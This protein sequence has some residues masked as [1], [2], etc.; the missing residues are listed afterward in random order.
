[1]IVNYWP[2]WFRGL[3][4]GEWPRSY[5][6]VDIESSGY[7][8]AEDVVTEWGHCLVE[9]GKVV[10][11]LSLVIDWTG[12][13]NPPDH[14]LRRKLLQLDQGMRF[15]G[16]TCHMSHDLM[17][18][19]GMKPEKAFNFI[20]KFTDTIKEKRIPFVFHN[21]SFDEKMLAGNYLQFKFGKGFSFG[22]V[23]IDTEGVEK[24]SQAPDNA[25]MHPQR[26]DSLR[27]YF[28]RVRYTRIQG[29][30]SNMEPHCYTKYRFKEKHGITQDMLH[31]AKMDS[32]CCHLLMEE[33]ACLIT[34]P[35]TP[36]VYPNAD[37]KAARRP[38]KATGPSAPAVPA[39]TKR[40]RGQRR[41]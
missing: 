39:N 6:C 11:N 29:I 31:G 26:N 37:S 23:F 40:L 20:T 7:S 14:W 25:R 30:K 38:Q 32:Y 34:D 22:D 16:K 36:P 35:V 9:D 17:R 1:M 19:E 8:F 21:G 33:F 18:A 5:C 15:A 13:D 2:D 28:H 10:D 27:D 24:A 4:G 12:R 41:S 3:Y